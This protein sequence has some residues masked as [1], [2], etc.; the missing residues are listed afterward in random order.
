MTNSE[1]VQNSTARP[2][3]LASTLRGVAEAAREGKGSARPADE[4]IRSMFAAGA[5]APAAAGLYAAATVDQS[6]EFEPFVPAEGADQLPGLVAA[7]AEVRAQGDRIFSGGATSTERSE[8]ALAALS[9]AQYAL[10]DLINSA[11]PATAAGAAAL[12]EFAI[13]QLADDLS[14]DEE[15][16]PEGLETLQ[17]VIAILKG[18]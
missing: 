2:T 12:V 1:A 16:A 18:A 14:L 15:L 13:F 9:D 6:E 3:R 5:E 8:G 4:R 11:E 10:A 17:R 7:Y